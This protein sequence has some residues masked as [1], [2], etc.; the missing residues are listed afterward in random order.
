MLKYKISYFVD[1]KNNVAVNGFNVFSIGEF[2]LNSDIDNNILRID[3]FK[4]F[5]AC[6]SQG[7]GWWGTDIR[8]RLLFDRIV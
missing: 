8:S 3:G 2:W 6:R 4:V 1:E 5:R 7:Q